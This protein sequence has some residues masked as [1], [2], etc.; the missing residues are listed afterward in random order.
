MTFGDRSGGSPGW[1]MQTFCEES[2]E[3]KTL[4]DP[5]ATYEFKELPRSPTLRIIPGTPE[6]AVCIAPSAVR[7]GTPFT[8]HLKL[9]DRWGNPVRPPDAIVHPGFETTGVFRFTAV[10]PDTG[11]DGREQ[12]RP[13][14]SWNRSRVHARAGRTCTASPR[15]RSAPTRSTTT[16]ASPAM[17][18]CWTRAGTRATTSRSPT[19]SGTPST[20]CPD[21]STRPAGS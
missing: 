5:I 4:V 19:R 8:Y 10:D 6:R 14:R 20:G 15:R 2:F 16:S 7:V 9:E 13:R 3:F 17:P 21:A 18:P 11:L 12:P 1:R